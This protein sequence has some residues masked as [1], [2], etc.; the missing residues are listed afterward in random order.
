MVSSNI[1]RSREGKEI[2]END[3]VLR[4]WLMQGCDGGEQASSLFHDGKA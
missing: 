4:Y 1:T 2:W 3:D